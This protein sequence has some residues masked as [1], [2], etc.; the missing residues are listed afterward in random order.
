MDADKDACKM[1]AAAGAVQNDAQIDVLKKHQLLPQAPQDSGE[2]KGVH[3]TAGLGTAGLGAPTRVQGSEDDQS[4]LDDKDEPFLKPCERRLIPV[5][6]EFENVQHYCSLVANNLLA[7][8]WFDFCEG[9]RGPE[10]R[11]TVQ[12]ENVLCLEECTAVDGMQHHLLLISSSRYQGLHLVSGQEL[13]GLDRMY[14]TVK[15]PLRD[16]GRLSV[17][18]YGYMGSY[19]HEFKALIKLAKTKKLSNA[20]LSVLQP[21]R[22]LPGDYVS[23]PLCGRVPCNASQ[24]HAV[25]SLKFALEKIQGPPGT[26]KSTTI[27]HIISSRIPVGARVLVTCSRNVAVEALAQKLELWGEDGLVV[28]GN[29]LRMGET[30][31]KHLLDAKCGRQPAYAGKDKENKFSA[32]MQRAGRELSD[33]FNQVLRIA[34]SCRSLLWRRAWAAYVRHKCLYAQLLSAWALR[35]G[36]AGLAHVQIAATACKADILKNSRIMLCTIATTS[37]RLLREWEEH[38]DEAL[39]THTVIV[40]E[41]G[42]TTESSVALLMRMDPKNVILL[43][44]HKQLPPLSLIP[45]LSLHGTKHD[46]SLL[47]RCVATSS[48]SVHCLVQ[49]YRMHQSI[50]QLDSYLFY[51]S[52]L[53]TPL[54]VCEDRQRKENRPLVWV[55][56]NGSETIALTNKSFVNH[57]EI[58]AVKGVLAKLRERHPDA[59]IAVLTFYKGQLEEMMRATPASLQ[60][61]IL[62]VDSSQGIE[63][64]YVVLSPVRSNCH[65]N[66]GFV[67]DDR[68]INVAISR[69]RYGLIVVGDDRTL[70]A[71]R[72]W[73]AVR[74]ACQG[75]GPD[76]WQPLLPLPLAGSF[77][78]V[79]DHLK[80]L[81]MH[82]KEEALAQQE[83]DALKLMEC[84]VSFR[85]KKLSR[86]SK[87]SYTPGKSKHDAGLGK[88]GIN[89]GIVWASLPSVVSWNI[90]GRQP[91][92]LAIQ[93]QAGMFH[94][95]LPEE[96]LRLDAIRRDHELAHRLQIEEALPRLER[97]IQN[98][99]ADLL[100]S[101]DLL[102]WQACL[103]AKLDSILKDIYGPFARLQAY[104]SSGMTEK[105]SC[106]CLSS[107]ADQV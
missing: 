91:V 86:F 38:C 93:S 17:R 9:P 37:S 81:Q 42:S 54:V 105:L 59:S 8:F 55:S 87:S 106:L 74:R 13:L 63:F 102:Q 89:V 26:G 28:F 34:V 68:R 90:S 30:A 100:P 72:N 16:R 97:A 22:D 12:G 69:S 19:M 39:E 49:Q 65:G 75:T 98:L 5:P 31:R 20:M 104:G 92:S 50:C 48:G 27:H 29:A 44:D 107:R 51:N 2:R 35:V 76:D 77:E 71:D 7:E 94:P 36:A 78:T 18:S 25:S 66:I 70:C 4:A 85:T 40:D 41:C 83:V 57:N 24:A 64:D 52:M 62:T 61:E 33:G 82:K 10:L 56:V 23:R 46:R 67:K 43:G 80:K 103:I 32:E 11:G 15:P 47:E 96:M 95:N 21:S 101:P 6:D 84:Q 79:M 53:Q 73:L 45:P 14:L 3:C 60:V 99:I 1:D 58:N 88:Q